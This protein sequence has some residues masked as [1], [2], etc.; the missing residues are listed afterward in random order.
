M[1][2]A[3]EA[4]QNAA[5][6]TS[7][8]GNRIDSAV[9]ANPIPT[10]AQGLLA[11]MDLWPALRLA[12]AEELG[13]P[14]SAEKRTWMAS[15][16]MDYFEEA[17]NTAKASPGAS[18]SE[19]AVADIIDQDDLAD[20]LL[21]MLSDEFTLDLDD[22][23]DEQVAKDIIQLWKEVVRGETRIAE[24]FIKAASSN[25]GKKP[26]GRIAAEQEVDEN[27]NPID[28]DDDDEDD[29]DEDYE[30]D[31]DAMDVD[32]E[33]APK[34]VEAKPKQEPVVDEDGFEL[35][36]KKGGKRK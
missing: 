5:A 20:M 29:D 17:Y 28:G 18:S 33:E 1:K 36:Q 14:D 26:A 31:D 34:L 32:D 15:E 11:I 13:G 9:K 24:A 16:V 12:V 10:F 3:F 22:G 25:K 7:A 21:G 23:S 6:T 30:T 2:A 27:G 19:E 35:V 8:V 4:K